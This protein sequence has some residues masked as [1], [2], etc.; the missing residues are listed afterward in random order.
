MDPGVADQMMEANGGIKA[1][2]TILID[3]QVV[4]GFDRHRL[5]ELLGI[6]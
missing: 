2:P 1:I 6:Y 4:T 3:D 5:K